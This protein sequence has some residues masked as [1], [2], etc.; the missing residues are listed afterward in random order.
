[1]VHVSGARLDLFDLAVVELKEGLPRVQVGVH[2]P[3]HNDNLGNP[4]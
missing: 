3:D 1:M 4:P 2:R